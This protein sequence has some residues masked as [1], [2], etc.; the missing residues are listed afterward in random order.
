VNVERIG[1]W[2][3]RRRSAIATMLILASIAGL[4]Q[5]T[6]P[7]PI[8]GPTAVV[9]PSAF[10]ISPVGDDVARLSPIT[11]TFAKAP[12]EREPEKLF[13]L[14][15]EPTGSYA[16]QSARTLLFQPDFPGL[17]RGSTYTIT[18]PARADANLPKAISRKFT[19]AGQLAVQQVIPGDGDTEVPLNAQVIVQFSRSVAPLTTLG[20]QRSDPIVTFDPPLHGKAEWLNTSIYRFL[21]EDL[22]S[23]TTY[24]MRIAKGLASAAD[25]VLQDDFRWAFTTVTPAVDAISPVDNTKFAGPFQEVVVRFNQPMDRSA[26]NGISVRGSN[27]PG[28]ILDAAVAGKFTWSEGD[29]VVI[30][31]PTARMGV[32]TKYTVTVAKGLKGAHG[33]ETAAARTSTFTTIALPSISSTSPKNGDIDAGRFGVNL[34]FATPMDPTTLHDKISISSFTAKDL[35]GRIS[36]GENYVSANVSLKPSS[37]YTVTLAPGATDRYGQVM[38]GYTFSFRTGALPSSVSLALPGYSSS[39]VYSASAEPILYFQITNLPSVT[40]TLWPLTGEEGRRLLHDFSHNNQN[41][42][43]SQPAMRTWAETVRGEKDEV[44]LGSTSLSGKGPLRKGYYF[45]QTSGKFASQFAFA[46]IDTV[47]VTKVSNDELLAWAID[48]DTG[49]PLQGVTVRSFGGGISP[50]E[51]K[52]DANGLASF[53]VPVPLLGKN[54][55]R[56]Y[57]LWIDGAGRNAVL[58]TRWQQGTS[59][60]Q[61]GLPSEYYAREWVGQVYTDRPI[62]RPGETVEYKGILRADDDARYT[63]PSADTPFRFVMQNARGQQ[64]RSE[65]LKLS[66][67]GSFAGSFALPDDAP[68]GNYSFGV[69]FKRDNN[70]WSIAS[71][72]FLVAEF[73]KPELQVEVSAAKTS[74]VDGEAIDVR[75]TASYFFGGAV[76]GAQVSWS[77]LADP[78]VLRVPGYESY[79]FSDYDY[80]RQ[81]V[82]REAVRASGTAT[83]GADGVASFRIPATLTTSEG[84]QRFTLSGAVT[85]QNA[86]VVAGS[87]QVTVHPADFYAG[88]RPAEYIASAGTDARIDLVSVSTDGKILANRTAV[89]KVYEREWITT[90]EQT[91]GGGRLYRSEPRDTLVAT[92]RATTNAKGDGSVTYRPT[93]PGTLRIVAEA[94]DGGGRVARSATYLWVW[95]DS[96]ASW[97]VTNDDAIKLVA[98]RDRYEVGDTAD[99]LV[100]APFAGGIGLVTIERGKVITKS[101]QKFPTNSERLRIPITDRSV[102]DV[103][104]SVVLYWPPTTADPI[105]RYKVG[106]VELTVSTSTRVLNVSAKTDRTQAKPGDTVRYDIKVTDKSGRGVRSEVSVAVIDKAVL[107]LQEERGPDG[108]HAFWFERGLSVSTASSMAVSVDRYNDAIAEPPRQGKG[109]SGLV[110]NQTRQDFRNTAYWKAQLVTKDDGTASVDVKMPDNLT[111]WRMQARAISGDTMVGEGTNELL[112]TKPLL[113][114]P[115]LPRF[116]RVGDSG[117]LR[118]LVRNATQAETQVSVVLKAQGVTVSGDLTRSATVRSSES[119]VM[120]WPAKAEAEGTANLTF[121]AT[122]TGGLEDSVEQELPVMLDVTPETMATGGIV[123]REGALEAVYLPKFAIQEH[124]SLT[125]SVRSALVGTM[126]EELALLK[127]V[128]YEGAERV[129]SRLIASIGVRRAEK[130]AGGTTVSDGRV[131]SDLAG[132]V[133]RQRPDGGWSWCDD[134]RCQSDPNVTGWALLALGEAQRDGLAVDTSVVQSASGYVFGYVNRATDLADPN[135]KAFLLEALASAG[136]RAAA[137]TPARALF[138]QYR[139]KL[140]S[141]GKA[142]LLLALTEAGAAKDDAQVRAL[143]DDLAAATIPSANGNHWEDEPAATRGSF[144]TTT[145]TTALAALALAR[146]RPDH[147]LLPQTVRWLV[148]AR[149]ADGWHTSVDRA[150]G[151]LALTSY[152]VSTGELAGDYSYKVLLDDKDVL[153]GL[154]T[155][156]AAATSATKSVPLTTLTPGKTNLLAI[157]REYQKPGRLYYTLDLRYVT[158]AKEV[159]AV[160]RGF[161]ISHQYTLIDDPAMPAARLFRPISSAK[162]GDTVRVT[163]TVMTASDHPYVVIEDLLPS[164]L[165]PV[166]ARLKNVDPALIAKLNADQSTAAGRKAGSYFAPWFRWYY[167]PWQHVELRDDR[168]VLYATRLAKGV[169]EYIYYARATTPGNFFVAPAH[170]EET[171]SPEIFGR[172]DSSRFVVTP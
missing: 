12:E 57:L 107:S 133:G 24:R 129:A 64:V 154:V 76:E 22:A 116:L 95:G 138:E 143:F 3:W 36:A 111:T 149:A 14:E 100:P 32:E 39:A 105:P 18:V 96:F 90:K 118:V 98:D 6:G 68:L 70:D 155:P 5:T 71:N 46:V 83:T 26:A 30:F 157:T 40:F 112:S 148:V 124:G 117:E 97:Q 110:S 78:F 54:Q 162:L 126:A 67:F 131:A 17:V 38:G 58:S 160:N 63:L 140:A 73:R 50:E 41:F 170:A 167:S 85:D 23:A 29:A 55:D 82:S 104:V 25:G 137:A 13:Q 106:Y 89:V 121:I 80:W 74:Y 42:T 2:L 61:F 147:V 53:S 159:E 28:G 125:V 158:P 87:T 128:P 48:H 75:T 47:L 65:T 113:L 156:G 171:Y 59:P 136:G 37:P 86:Q 120:S 62:Y 44:L 168:A 77:A 11:V 166:D 45:V 27:L 142:Y 153:A 93:R 132:V 114:R 150:L 122:G 8:S 56:T 66:E 115:A 19:V 33:S 72:S 165:E 145:G 146:I 4:I 81:S 101:V 94:T 103:F 108:L 43:P 51:S 34:E 163:L 169:Y 52:T 16:W 20:A 102:P 109:G 123:N 164:G 99:I 134:P 35:E 60:F 91:P 161:A 119:A 144:V 151:V 127:P 92:L 10:A 152:A 15:P 49:A 84:A 69:E 9:E 130:T 31:N 141:W 7:G 135:Q 139:A 79:S 1:R 88:V 172:S 21:P